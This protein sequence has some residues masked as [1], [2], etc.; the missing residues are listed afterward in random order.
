MSDFLSFSGQSFAFLLS[1]IDGQL[2]IL[3]DWTTTGRCHIFKNY[4]LNSK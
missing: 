2:A 1:D 4:S 3:T